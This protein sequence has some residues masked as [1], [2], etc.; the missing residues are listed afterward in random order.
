MTP[1]LRSVSRRGAA[2]A[3]LLLFVFSLSTSLLPCSDARAGGTGASHHLSP[4][5]SGDGS[6]VMSHDMAPAETP[7]SNERPAPGNDMSCPL[8]IACSGIV[9]FA[10][11]LEWRS[12]VS[13]T[14]TDAPSGLVLARASADRDVDSPPP[15]R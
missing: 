3:Q 15:R 14:P 6:H 9:Q 12:V 4:D 5:G 2:F 1:V 8:M 11:D 13:S 7:P 10:D